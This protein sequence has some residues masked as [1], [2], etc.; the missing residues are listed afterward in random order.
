MFRTL[1]HNEGRKELNQCSSWLTPA[2]A[3][4]ASR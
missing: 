3:V 4:T 2:P 1:E